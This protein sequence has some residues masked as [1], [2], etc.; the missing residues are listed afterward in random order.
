[1]QKYFR[2]KD[3][4]GDLQISNH[5]PALRHI[6]Q[7]ADALPCSQSQSQS[8]SQALSLGAIGRG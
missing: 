6:D 3:F 2:L 4:W 5:A 8:Q 1:L 7:S